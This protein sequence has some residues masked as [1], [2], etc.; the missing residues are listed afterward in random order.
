MALSTYLLFCL[1]VLLSARFFSLCVSVCGS[2]FVRLLARKV[3]TDGVI[4]IS[5][6]L[7]VCPVVRK[8]FLSLCFCLWIWFREVFS[9]KS[10]NRW[11][12]RHNLFS[13]CLSCCPQGFAV[14]FCLWI[15]FREVISEKSPNRWRYQHIWVF[16][17]SVCPVVRQGFCA[18][19]PRDFSDWW[20]VDD[21]ASAWDQLSTV[22]A[23]ECWWRP[24]AKES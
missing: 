10:P 11:R 20:C 23:L 16:F 15:W 9:E 4:D 2:G 6:F 19:A 1:F 22:L 17:L 18:V 24:S 7:S 8:V 14:V 12:Y 13:V 21:C 5:S 3:P